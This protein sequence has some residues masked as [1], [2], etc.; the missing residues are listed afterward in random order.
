MGNQEPCTTRGIADIFCFFFFTWCF[1]LHD[2]LFSTFYSNSS[3]SLH[4]P[5]G[6]SP[7]NDQNSK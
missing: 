5:N 2:I 4:D 1:L 3:N 7:Y 6:A